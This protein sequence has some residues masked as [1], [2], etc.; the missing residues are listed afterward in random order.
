MKKIVSISLVLMVFLAA[1]APSVGS[2]SDGNTGSSDSGSSTDGGQVVNPPVAV[3]TNTEQAPVVVALTATANINLNCRFGPGTSY[4]VVV[5]VDQGTSANIIAKNTSSSPAWYKLQLAD[6]TECWASSDNLVISGSVAGLS[7]ITTGFPTPRPPNYWWVGTWTIWQN[8]CQSNA[9]SCE[10]IVTA[11]FT[12]TGPNTI[13]ASY[14]AIG[15]NWQDSLTVSADGM[16]ADGINKCLNT[17]ATWEA[18]LRMDPNHNQFRGRWNVKGSL[19]SDGYYAGAR[20]GY[21][22]PDPTR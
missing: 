16:Y 1:C 17:G 5:V 8:E 7:E 14:A 18:H 6:N 9:P 10:E 11:T 13:V 12:A 15:C 4:D 20:N 3:A 19:T 22:K 21:G 2:S